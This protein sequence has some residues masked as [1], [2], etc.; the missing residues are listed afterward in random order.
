M[1]LEL[2]S[3]DLFGPIRRAKMHGRTKSPKIHWRD[4]LRRCDWL[5]VATVPSDGKSPPATLPF[6]ITAV[7]II[8]V[9]CS[10]QHPAV[11]G[12]Q[13]AHR[14]FSFGSAPQHVANLP[15]SLVLTSVHVPR[16]SPDLIFLSSSL[17][18]FLPLRRNS[19]D[20]LAHR[21]DANIQ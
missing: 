21:S 8:T 20:L 6:T 17:L 12:R 11:F 3:R 15:K 1:G 16:H 13:G 2:V 10:G 5:P 18:P 14:S 19:I 9:D 7:G 4:L